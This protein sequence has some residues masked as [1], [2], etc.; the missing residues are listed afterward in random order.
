MT[1]RDSDMAR[2]EDDE[3]VAVGLPATVWGILLLAC[4]LRITAVLLRFEN[5][6]VDRDA[7]LAIAKNL[8]DGHGFCSTI[9]QPTAFRPPLYP[10]MV[11]ICLRVGG[12]AVLGITQVILGTVTVWLTWQLAGMCRL[13]RRVGLVAT[14]LVAVDPLLIEYTTQPM[15][16][17]L[18]AFLVTVLL[19]RTLKGKPS[20][21]KS[22]A[23]G[24]IFGL[25]VL[26]RPSIWAFGGLASGIW[27]IVTLVGRASSSSSAVRRS[28]V[29]SLAF[30]CGVSTL[31][32]VSPWVIRN[33]IQFG[34]PIFM[35][36]HGGYTLLLGNN[37]RF[38]DEVVSKDDRVAWSAT[39]LTEWQAENE[40][41]LSAMEISRLDEPAR[42]RQL[43][44]FARDWIT[45]NPLRF[46]QCSI[47]RFQRF[48]ALR[49]STSNSTVPTWL[50]QLVGAFYLGVFTL[51][52]VGLLRLRNRIICF[53]TVPVM[54]LS[55]TFVH[56]VYWS[57]A[58]MRC[59]VVPAV[60]LVSAV[61]IQRSNRQ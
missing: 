45:S 39:G 46:V 34:R 28:R 55:L 35:T 49:P 41:R 6:H 57:N 44:S 3:P 10:L 27:M 48:W 54:I 17:T 50:V 8:L 20:I 2:K 1:A 38:Y 56:L 60:S 47:L 11:A 61:A 19:W 18:S 53:W 40:R 5:I 43:A 23:V 29:V 59:A 58:R 25:A 26:C 51:A 36:T 12:L 9:S 42:D 4:M 32:V 31:L 30:A 21:S 7:Y 37:E 16:E 33:V 24:A 22:I 15:T 13:S 14:F 52:L